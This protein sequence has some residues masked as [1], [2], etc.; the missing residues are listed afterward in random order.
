VS[1]HN[2]AV[3]SSAMQAKSS[4]VSCPTCGCCSRRS[5]KDRRSEGPLLGRAIRAVVGAHQPRLRS[6]ARVQRRTRRLI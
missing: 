1:D 3:V 4:S 2:A 6:R 5:R